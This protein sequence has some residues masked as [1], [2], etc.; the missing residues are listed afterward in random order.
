M[1]FIFLEAVTF[2]I[3][4]IKEKS[5]ENISRKYINLYT[6]KSHYLY[7]FLIFKYINSIQANKVSSFKF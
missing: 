6:E 7:N 4:P 3:R 2:M 1:E 5:N